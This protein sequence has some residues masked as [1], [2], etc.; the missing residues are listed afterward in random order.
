[1][2][3]LDT[4]LGALVE[5]SGL[6]NFF[7]IGEMT[8]FAP[9]EDHR[10]GHLRVCQTGI[11]IHHDNSRSVLYKETSIRKAY[12]FINFIAFFPSAEHLPIHVSSPE[13][14]IL[15]THSQCFVN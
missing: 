5:T 6:T 8:Q 15:C 14:L 13:S 11:C 10:T 7:G 4:L 9:P 3:D 2:H 1:M 12:W